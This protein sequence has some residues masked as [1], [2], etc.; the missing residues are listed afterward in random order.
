MERDR[1][2]Y[3]RPGPP[4][5]DRSRS[6]VPVSRRITWS[7]KIGGNVHRTR[8]P[9]GVEN[10]G[11]RCNAHFPNILYVL[12]LVPKRGAWGKRVTDGGEPTSTYA[13]E[14]HTH[15]ALFHCCSSQCRSRI[16]DFNRRQQIQYNT[17]RGAAETLEYSQDGCKAPRFHGEHAHAEL[18]N[19]H[20]SVV[21]CYW[22]KISQRSGRANTNS[23]RKS[24]HTTLLAIYL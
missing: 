22:S 17:E 24:N 15:P 11:G 3:R 14:L 2:W 9:G 7:S 20:L 12:Q 23:T 4:V 19:H 21:I 6:S 16:H 18:K 10:V 1:D 5:L 8:M 13:I